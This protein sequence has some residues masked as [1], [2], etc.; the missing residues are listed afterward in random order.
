MRIDATLTVLPSLTHAVSRR[1]AYFAYI[2]SGEHPVRLRVLGPD[3]ITPGNTGVVRLHLAAP[4]PLV[5]GDRFVLR[6]S[7][8]DETV[9]GG[10]VLDVAPVLPASKARPSTNV[11]RVVAERGWVTAEDLEALTGERRDPTLAGWVVDPAAL[12]SARSTV[13]DRVAASGDLGLDIATLDA[14]ER[15]VLALLDD[16]QVDAGRARP[17]ATLDPFADHPFLAVLDIAGVSPPDPTGV[18]RVELRELVRRKLVV[19]RDGAYFHPRAIELAT[20]VAADLLQVHPDGF[21]MSQ[22]RDALGTTRKHAL[23]LGT[24]LDSRGIT[25]RRGD[26]RIAGPRLP[27]RP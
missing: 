3:S 11:D 1:G 20:S 27:Q 25:R 22:F 2:G 4:L 21:T 15:A 23:P 10:E 9:G 14:R 8:R 16:V 6:E 18:D 19:E 5:M 13:R 12:A 26:L 17:I 7:G 24:E